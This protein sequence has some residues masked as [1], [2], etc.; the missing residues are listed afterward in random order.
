MR[1]LEPF[2]GIRMAAGHT[3]FHVAFFIG[4]FFVR[5]QV[6]RDDM[7]TEVDQL[8]PFH[9]DGN[10][11]EIMHA[12]VALRY[13]HLVCILLHIPSLFGNRAAKKSTKSD[14]FKAADRAT[15]DESEN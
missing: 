3:L 15:H 9:D 8:L 13:A 2:A 5:T 7:D 12:F 11:S 4:T 10:L 1:L 14:V 6:A